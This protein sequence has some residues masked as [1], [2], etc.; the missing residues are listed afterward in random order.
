MSHLQVIIL[1]DFCSFLNFLSREESS[2]CYWIER[3]THLTKSLMWFL[4]NQD[5]LWVEN[6]VSK[7][8]KYCQ[9]QHTLWN[10]EWFLSSSV[11]FLLLADWCEYQK[12]RIHCN[13]DSFLWMHLSHLHLKVHTLKHTLFLDI[14][15]L[16]LVRLV[17][18]IDCN[19]AW[20]IFNKGTLHFT[21]K[22]TSMNLEYSN[23]CK[24]KWW[25]LHCC[26][27]RIHKQ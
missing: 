12:I 18:Y 5:D 11:L 14:F 3:N 6:L 13:Q 2:Q 26:D 25:D 17:D 10:W 22:L 21:W 20:K 15:R 24:C 9:L 7:M 16:A 1:H 23:R 4:S 27:R 19:L 8:N